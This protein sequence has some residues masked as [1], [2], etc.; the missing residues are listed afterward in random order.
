MFHRPLFVTFAVPLSRQ[1]TSFNDGGLEV[2]PELQIIRKENFHKGTP[3]A[4]KSRI[5][6][7]GLQVLDK[8]MGVGNN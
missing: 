7:S 1:R 6:G 4:G 2:I 5:G 8:R 3:N